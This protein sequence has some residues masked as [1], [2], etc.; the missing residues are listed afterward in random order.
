MPVSD[1]DRV[2]QLVVEGFRALGAA[3]P[4]AVSRAILLRE[5]RFVGHRFRCDGIQALRLAGEDAIAFYDDQGKL[6]KTVPLEAEPVN[7]AA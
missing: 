5:R 2:Y 3:D 7:R 4:E 6:L 1:A